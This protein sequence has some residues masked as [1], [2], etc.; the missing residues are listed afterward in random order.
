MIHSFRDLIVWQKA[1]DTVVMIYGLTKSFPRDEIYGLTSQIRRAAISIPS[2]I[3]EGH[4]RD[5][6]KE[7]LYHLS[8]AYG[9]LCEVQTQGLIARRLNYITQQEFGDLNQTV[10]EIGRMINGLRNK[11]KQE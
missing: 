9:S 1:I 4:G 2:N 3:A 11:L 7:F 8:I 6:T 5:S 10:N